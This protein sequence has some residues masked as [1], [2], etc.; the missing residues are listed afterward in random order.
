MKR[1]L[2]LLLLSS[3]LIQ[4]PASAQEDPNGDILKLIYT[5]IVQSIDLRRKGVEDTANKYFFVVAQPGI[6]IDPALLGP[7]GQ[8][9]GQ[10]KRI[11]SEI[12]D[13]VMLP[14]WVYGPKDETYHEYYDLIL[15]SYEYEPLPLPDSKK[16]Q[17][18]KAQ[19]FLYEPDGTTPTKAYQ[20]YLDLQRKYLVAFDTGQAWLL[21]NPGASQL[22]LTLSTDIMNAENAWIVAGR[23][24]DVESAIETTVRYTRDGFFANARTTFRA[25][26]AGAS[27]HNYY[28][29]IA[30]WLD[31]AQQWPTISVSWSKSDAYT[32]N[33]H[34]AASGSGGFNFGGFFSV[35][36][37]TNFDR[38]H[39][40]EQNEATKIDVTF[41]YMR[42]DFRRPWLT[43]RVFSDSRWR[44]ACGTEP[45][46]RKDL[47]S[48]GPGEETAETI[49]YPEGLMPLIP[50]GFL[51]VRNAKV[52]GN[53]AENFSDY[54]K[55]VI[56]ASGSGGWG[57][58]KVRGS[59][60]DTVEDTK[61][62]AETAANGFK[63][64]HPQIIGFFTEV[65][66][67]SPTPAEGLFTPC[68]ETDAE[69]EQ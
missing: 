34:T 39:N 10:L 3:A 45:A 29:S 62:E 69:P 32:H 38:I 21:R 55:R 5:K 25:T 17:L 2:S 53:F 23:R 7:D 64:G 65:L 37:G 42:V 14:S 67:R 13:R 50:T 59:Y 6:F 56:S 48:S 36:G 33:H 51:I 1:Y 12:I 66:P 54:Y 16:A 30:T 40:V 9:N 18:D 58:F 4:T 61:V 60:S 49:E 28:P 26:P 22:P 8:E 31:D 52:E 46:I 15:D 41:E 63:V 44:F 43:R 11:F 68:E 57:P 35:G 24:A 20:T 27:L 19:V 47:V